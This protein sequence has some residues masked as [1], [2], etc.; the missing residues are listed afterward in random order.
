MFTAQTKFTYNDL[1]HSSLSPGEY[2]FICIFCDEL[3]DGLAT[4]LLSSDKVV[5][6]LHDLQKKI[7]AYIAN[8][9]TV[10]N[11]PDEFDLCLAMF[12]GALRNYICL[13]CIRCGFLFVFFFFRFVV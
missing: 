6:Q 5:R 11:N 12:E 8:E 4:F 10:F 9:A 7:D 13:V 2:P 1:K 3:A